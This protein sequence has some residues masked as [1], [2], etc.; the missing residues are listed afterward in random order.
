[1]LIHLISDMMRDREN[2][3]ERFSADAQAIFAE[4]ELSP[5]EIKLLRTATRSRSPRRSPG[6]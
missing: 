4:Y 5:R 6:R 2:L 3:R 1:M